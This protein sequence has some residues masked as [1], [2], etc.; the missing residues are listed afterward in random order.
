MRYKFITLIGITVLLSCTKPP[1]YPIEP[2]IKFVAWNKTTIVQG[3]SKQDSLKL[4]LSFTDGDG[5]LGSDQ[6]NISRINMFVIDK[7]KNQVA[8]SLSIP[9]VPVEGSRNGISGKLEASLFTTCCY[10]PDAT[11]PCT[12]STLYAYD[13]VTYEVFI[14]DRAGHYSN[15]VITEPILVQC[16]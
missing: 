10:F 11:P 16:K 1:N 8:D 15:K 9:Y 5:D 7:R 6:T 13:T 2:V 4:I 14:K 12:P 3:D